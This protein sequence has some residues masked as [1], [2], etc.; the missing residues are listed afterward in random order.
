M[1]SA[2]GSLNGALALVED[3]VFEVGGI[4]SVVLGG[5][6]R[7]LLGTSVDPRWVLGLDTQLPRGTLDFG[8]NHA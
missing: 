6:M 2:V 3:A 1:T 4:L 7:G 8:C 5:T